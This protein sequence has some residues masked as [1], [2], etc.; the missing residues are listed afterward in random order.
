MPAIRASAGD[1]HTPEEL[2]LARAAREMIA[3][4]TLGKWRESVGYRNALNAA[5]NRIRH[6]VA[7]HECDIGLGP[8]GLGRLVLDELTSMAEAAAEEELSE[9]RRYIPGAQRHANG[10]RHSRGAPG[11]R[12]VEV[13]V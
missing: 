5:V 3:G 12:K 1:D 9:R 11:G 13:A 10:G 8:S 7:S 2:A 4:G 6:V